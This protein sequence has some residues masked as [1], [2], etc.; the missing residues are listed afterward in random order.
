[1]AGLKKGASKKEVFSYTVSALANYTEEQKGV[2]V[3]R[4][5]FG[6]K[7]IE[8]ATPMLGVKTAETI[9]VMATDAVFQAG[10]TC[11]FNAS[12]TTTF[13]QRT[14]TVGKVKV[15]ETLCPDDLN[16]K[17]LQYALKAGSNQ[18]A[19]PFEDTYAAL[20]A[21]IIAEQMETAFW[22][23]DTTSATNNLSYFDGLLK[24][25]GYAYSATGVYNVNAIT[26]TGTIAATSGDPTFTLTGG[27]LTTMGI[28][29]G[30][31]V[32]VSGTTYTVDSVTDATHFEATANAAANYSGASY[33]WIPASATAFTTPWTTFISNTINIFQDVY[34][35]IPTTWLDKSD[36][37]CFCGWDVYRRLQMEITDGNLFHYKTETTGEMILPGTNLKIVAVNGLNST[38]RIICLPLSNMF[39][40]TD[41]MNEYEDFK[42]WY[43]EDNEHVRYSVKWKAGTQVA[44]LNQVVQFTLA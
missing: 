41:L 28:V 25:I 11:A 17:Y 38:N 43:S 5:L 8:M 42:I 40:G 26:A 30:D 2:L 16:A 4:A 1:M 23:G 3:T 13:T 14:M 35:T 37:V 21:G 44:F 33:T 36:V 12:G 19:I 32:R 10:G 24:N 22:Q 18:D 9:N 31:K 7:S 39:F 6:A 27:S 20:K 29:A 15:Q 34:L